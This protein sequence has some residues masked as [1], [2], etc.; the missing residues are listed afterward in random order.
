MRFCFSLAVLFFLGLQIPGV[1]SGA[2]PQVALVKNINQM[3]NPQTGL[4]PRSF[5]NAGAVT[6]FVGKNALDQDELW[7]TD[8]TPAGTVRILNMAGGAQ[9][10]EQLTPVAGKL[11]FTMWDAAHGTELWVSDGTG[12]AG[13]THRVADLLA[14]PGSAEPRTLSPFADGLIFVAQGTL[15]KRGLWFTDG[16]EAGTRLVMNLPP[17]EDFMDYP[18]SARW[19]ESN[20]LFYF[21]VRIGDRQFFYR[22]DGTAQ[23]TLLLKELPSGNRAGFVK[24]GNVVLFR[25]AA[26]AGNEELWKTDGTVK[27]TV[28]LKEIRAGAKGGNPRLFTPVGNLV[29]FIA[30]QND[31]GSALWRSDGTA[32]GTRQVSAITGGAGAERLVPVGNYLL[33]DRYSVEGWAGQITS[34][35]LSTG[36]SEDLIEFEYLDG[37]GGGVHAVTGAGNQAFFASYDSQNRE[38]LWVT[39]GTKPGTR[40]IEAAAT[41]TGGTF[42]QYIGTAGNAA[43]FPGF[44]QGSGTELWSS[45]G[46]E[47]GTKLVYDGPGQ[48]GSSSPSSLR[49]AGG[50]MYF[51]ADDGV[52]G[53]ELWKTDGT[54]AGTVIVKDI[55]P[56]EEAGL[57]NGSAPAILTEM[58]GIV[59]FSA[60]DGTAGRELWRTD[61]SEAGTRRVRDIY[62]GLAGSSPKNAAVFS[63]RLFFAANSAQGEELWLSDGTESGTVLYANLSPDNGG[64]QSSSPHQLTVAGD[65][66]YFVASTQAFTNGLW[67]MTAGAAP[68]RV[69]SLHSLHEIIA[70]PPAPGAAY[71]PD[72]WIIYVVNANNPGRKLW[73]TDG[74]VE[75]TSEVLNFPYYTTSTV[76]DSLQRLP[77]G[78]ILLRCRISADSPASFYR[79]HGADCQLLP[80]LSTQTDHPLEILAAGSRVYM[81]LKKV[82]SPAVQEIWCVDIDAAPGPDAEPRRVYQQT[83]GSSIVLAKTV[84]QSLFFTAGG[85]SGLRQ[86]WTSAGTEASTR[87]ITDAEVYV[88]N[89]APEWAVMGSRVYLSAATGRYGVEL[90][91]FGLEGYLIVEDVT[92]VQTRTLT[93][94][95]TLD[96]GVLSVGQSRS[97]TLRLVNPGTQP[98]TG[99]TVAQAESSSLPDYSLTSGSVTSLAGGQSVEVEITFTPAQS[100]MRAGALEVRQ[101]SGLLF[102]L[103]LTG[104]GVA[105]DAAPVITQFPVS[106]IVRVGADMTFSADAISAQEL[107]LDWRRDGDAT[108]GTQ[109]TLALTNVQPADAGNYA[110]TFINNTDSVTTPPAVLAVVS[111]AVAQ[112]TV[113]EHHTLMLSCTAKAPAGCTLAYQW[114]VDGH[115]LTDDGRIQGSRSATLTIADH[116]SAIAAET[117]SYQGVYDC[118]VTLIAPDGR[119]TVS[120]GVTQVSVLPVPTIYFYPPTILLGEA[121][122]IQ[123]DTDVPATRFS[124][125]GLP[126]GLTLNPATGRITGAPT[127]VLPI[128][129]ATEEYG[130]YPVVCSAGNDSGDGPSETL[131]FHVVP[132]IPAGAYDGLLGRSDWIE[133]SLGGRVTVTSTTTGAQSGK[134]LYEGKS[135]ALAKPVI[136]QELTHGDLGDAVIEFTVSRGKTL[137]ALKL[138]MTT[139]WSSSNVTLTDGEPGHTVTGWIRNQT[140]RSDR[141]ALAGLFTWSLRN[142]DPLLNSDLRVPGGA[143]YLTATVSKTATVTWKG[144]LAD[145]TAV[146]GSGLLTDASFSSGLLQ[147]PVHQDLYSL[148]GSVH[149]WVLMENGVSPSDEV[150]L[151]WFKTALP[152]TS[153]ERKYKDGIRLHPV[154]L[155]GGRYAAPGR[156]ETLFGYSDGAAGTVSLLSPG[157]MNGGLYHSFTLTKTNKAVLDPF[158]A[159]SP[160]KV[161][162]FNAAQGTFKGSFTLS[163]PNP[164]VPK[165]PWTRVVPFEGVILPDFY[166]MHGYFMMPELPQ[167]GPPATTL[168]TS[169][170]RS[171]MVQIDF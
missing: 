23:G 169:P 80:Y 19:A 53:S 8:G 56:G 161:L 167:A 96:L 11:F 105:A 99:L 97:R 148:K 38:T 140:Q 42:G 86:V 65:T 131:S 160:V 76:M 15:Q 116:S 112:V 146:T 141:A 22:T 3:Q 16:T 139:D 67:Q 40:V 136:V 1:I 130:A 154:T 127:K 120:H 58:N 70:R 79:V 72:R 107:T 108:V 90:H 128:N 54:E 94:D 82:S 87:K 155:Q 119:D 165:R 45:D 157:I 103:V 95:G 135:Y 91:S 41:A 9:F 102:N 66:L 30:N 132:A 138:R 115:A 83:G 77:D 44:V 85:S 4:R 164:A 60:A 159:E 64:A 75:G 143:G 84:Q 35:S 20:G 168:T 7:K 36:K 5:A 6:Y 21:D 25:A 48:E 26:K 18:S 61:G 156:G 74:T 113:A 162:S 144:K 145:G 88:P 142:Q 152:A 118:L 137:P 47:A 121:V 27:G 98:L 68:T 43:L 33:F 17:E 124:A 78:D 129:K 51:A 158:T 59:Y 117:G 57:P 93:A 126:P 153:K 73:V 24:A 55:W 163:D 134:L 106:R 46:T 63:D 100:G 114:T 28:L 170:I 14:G 81:S 32:A 166:T 2:D 29:Y 122:D 147:V 104:T 49:A 34:L 31:A 62:P 123:I 151:E 125:K 150:T 109:N 149:G 110:L 89:A 52:H 50:Q 12:Q 37:N 171:G 69:G 39:D 133:G 101:A 111:P 92:D 71:K 13:G 10:P